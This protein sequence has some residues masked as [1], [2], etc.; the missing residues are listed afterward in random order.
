MEIIIENKKS[1]LIQSA[2][3]TLISYALGFWTKIGSEVSYLSVIYAFLIFLC[4]FYYKFKEP[5]THPIVSWVINGMFAFLLGAATTDIYEP[6]L[7]LVPTICL[8]IYGLLFK[9]GKFISYK[10]RLFHPEHEMAYTYYQI[11][12]PVLTVVGIILLGLTAIFML[13]TNS[14]YTVFSQIM[15][16]IN[17]VVMSLMF[18]LSLLTITLNQTKKSVYTSAYVCIFSLYG[19]LLSHHY[20]IN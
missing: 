1:F 18:T 14:V 16:S 19:L 2:V 13:Q 15:F 4:C 12:F 10:F 5:S 11:V 9:F 20:L 17:L 7:L 8:L 3:I 6:D